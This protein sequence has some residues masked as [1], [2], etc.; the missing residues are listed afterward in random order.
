MAVFRLND[1]QQHH[2]RENFKEQKAVFERV[3]EGY[4]EHLAAEVQRVKNVARPTDKRR[5]VP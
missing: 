2:V 1:E 3:Y 4:A 5:R